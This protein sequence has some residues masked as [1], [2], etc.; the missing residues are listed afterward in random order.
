[1]FTIDLSSYNRTQN[2]CDGLQKMIVPI[3]LDFITA[4]CLVAGCFLLWLNLRPSG[5]DVILTKVDSFDPRVAPENVADQKAFFD[6]LQRHLSEAEEIDRTVT[7]DQNAYA[8]R[9]ASG[10]AKVRKA[11]TK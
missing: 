5:R 1:M 7:A 8:N 11:T 3:F 4:F 9:V 6:M 10:M 2:R